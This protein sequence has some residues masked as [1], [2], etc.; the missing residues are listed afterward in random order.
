MSQTDP[1]RSAVLPS[2]AAMIPAVEVE[3]TPPPAA[4]EAPTPAAEAAQTPEPPQKRKNA[5]IVLERMRSMDRN[6][7]KQGL[8]WMDAQS[9]PLSGASAPQPSQRTQP[10]T[11]QPRVHQT[12][13]GGAAL[14]SLMRSAAKRY[15]PP[16]AIRMPPTPPQH[17]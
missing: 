6:L 14:S 16:P 2:E 15:M 4:E 13:S 9:N 11:G 10:V 1:Y 7:R 17:R 3:E 5:S 8:Q 12:T